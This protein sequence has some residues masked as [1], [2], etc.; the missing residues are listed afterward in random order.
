MALQF[1]APGRADD[2]YAAG[3]SLDYDVPNGMEQQT[4]QHAMNSLCDNYFG[5]S[6]PFSFAGGMAVNLVVDLYG[7]CNTRV[8]GDLSERRTQAREVFVP[9]G[10]SSGGILPKLSAQS[11]WRIDHG[12]DHFVAPLRVSQ[13]EG[14][15]G[16]QR[17]EGKFQHF[18]LESKSGGKRMSIKGPYLGAAAAQGD[19]PPPAFNGDY[20]E[21]LRSYRTCFVHWLRTT[22]QKGK[23]PSAPKFAQ[24]LA[25]LAQDDA[26]DIEL[27]FARVY[28][29]PLSSAELDVDVLEGSFLRW[30]QKQK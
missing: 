6:I 13:A 18:R 11:R 20:L 4:V 30:L 21:F 15:K 8:D 22:S 5:D 2:D 1:S 29:V 28:G 23:R 10:A 19:V 14:A 24:L 16:K 12:A 9:G 7:E 26:A 3:V 25:E 17:R 27:A